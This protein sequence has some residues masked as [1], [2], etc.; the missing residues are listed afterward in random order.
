[1]T[2]AITTGQDTSVPGTDSVEDIPQLREQ[3]DAL[4][5]DIIQLVARR[6]QLSRRIQAARISGGGTRVALSR[7]RIILDAYRTA[8]GRSGAHLAE[9]VLEVCRGQR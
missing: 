5:A 6:Q 4:D 9:A 2:S 8:L 3:I 7:E 1:M